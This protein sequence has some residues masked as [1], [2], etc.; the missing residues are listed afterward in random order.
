MF[1][2]RTSLGRARRPGTAVSQ[3]RSAT[4]HCGRNP[5]LKTGLHVDVDGPRPGA[6]QTLGFGCY[7]LSGST[8]G[9]PGRQH[10]GSKKMGSRGRGRC[11]DHG[12]AAPVQRH[13]SH[14]LKKG[15]R[16]GCVKFGGVMETRASPTPQ[17]PTCKVNSESPNS[18]FKSGR[19]AF[20][21]LF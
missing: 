17:P 5:A 8:A 12:A 13:Q 2:Q 21:S 3:A 1:P 7:L 19:R 16:T 4:G 18:I 15:S 14:G 6:G 11:R 10:L 20:H 9:R